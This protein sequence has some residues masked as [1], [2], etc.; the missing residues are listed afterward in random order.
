MGPG[1][2]A[3]ALVDAARDPA[4]WGLRAASWLELALGAINEAAAVEDR[5]PGIDAACRRQRLALRAGIG[6]A[7]LVIAEVLSGEGPIFTL[8]PIENRD[9]WCYLFLLDQPVQH[10]GRSVGGIGGEPLRLETEALF[11]TLDHSARGI[12]LGLTDS[13]RCFDVHDHPVLHV[14]Q[15]VVGIG[16]ERRSFEGA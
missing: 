5:V 8:G 10:R 16:E 4:E 14:D 1:D 6:V 12:Y 9:V 13:P 3:G 7:A 11:S 15:V 2:I